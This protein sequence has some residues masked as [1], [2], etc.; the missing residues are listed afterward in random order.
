MYYIV[1]KRFSFNRFMCVG[2]SDNESVIENCKHFKDRKEEDE[3]L[4]ICLNKKDIKHV[5]FIP[6]KL[7]KYDNGLIELPDSTYKRIYDP[8]VESDLSYLDNN[9]YNVETDLWDLFSRSLKELNERSKDSYSNESNSMSI[10]C[11]GRSG[12]GKTYFLETVQKV[13]KRPS[14]IID[15]TGIKPTSVRDAITQ[16]LEKVLDYFNDD[17]EKVNNAIIMLD[18][19]D[20]IDV[21]KN[22][23]PGYYFGIPSGLV[24]FTKVDINSK[25]YGFDQ[26]Q[27]FNNLFILT[28][29]LSY[30][31]IADEDDI[32]DSIRLYS[33][34]EMNHYYA[35]KY[36]S[37][38][39]VRALSNLL[40]V[41]EKYYLTKGVEVVF[42]PEFE[43]E[44]KQKGRI[45]SQIQ[46]YPYYQKAIKSIF[47]KIDIDN[48]S[49]IT[50]YGNNRI[51]FE[52]KK[53]KV[54]SN[55]R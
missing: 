4:Y 48:Y 21:P 38:N 36:H 44:F 10:I 33:F 18:N 25:K 26:I 35:L 28:T 30:R 7:Y 49:K 45:K 14:V 24:Y 5:N 50:F 51:D 42:T 41:I 1:F 37:E 22:E 52:K 17:R 34:F 20:K 6:G 3:N 9:E 27:L 31:R 55:V 8:M 2:I 19:Y 16:I 13:S 23:L 40:E 32:D 53:T 11:Q 46:G 43:H 54:L 47:D 15:C 39:C 12:Y 29:S